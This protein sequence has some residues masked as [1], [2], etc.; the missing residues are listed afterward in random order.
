MI[1]LWCGRLAEVLH[2]QCSY[3]VS[4]PVSTEIGNRCGQVIYNLTSHLGP[5]NELCSAYQNLL[6]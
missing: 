1:F 4:D 5:N 2:Y 6:I 3:T